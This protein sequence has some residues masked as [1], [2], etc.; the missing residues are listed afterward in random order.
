[1]LDCASVKNC[2]RQ[3]RKDSKVI[4]APD[5]ILCYHTNKPATLSFRIPL[6]Q[7]QNPVAKANSCC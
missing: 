1:M 7:D 6:M 3:G 4:I 5:R 2:A